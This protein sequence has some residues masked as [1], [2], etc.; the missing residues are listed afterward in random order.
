LLILRN[1]DAIGPAREQPSQVGLA[2]RKGQGAQI[3]AWCQDIYDDFQ[4]ARYLTSPGSSDVAVPGGLLRP[5]ERCWTFVR[6]PVVYK[7]RIDLRDFS[8]DT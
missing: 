6:E 8:F 2:H 5:L 1:E 3:A 7:Q 4:S